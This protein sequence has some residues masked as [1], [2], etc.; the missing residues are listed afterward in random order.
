MKHDGAFHDLF[1]D[2]VHVGKWLSDELLLAF[3]G[4][5]GGP[6]KEAVQTVPYL[7]LTTHGQ[8]HY[9]GQMNETDP[10]AP[11]GRLNRSLAVEFPR[12]MCHQQIQR[13]TEHGVGYG[14]HNP[15]QRDHECANGQQSYSVPQRD[16]PVERRVGNSHHPVPASCV[17]GPQGVC[18]R[19]E[20]WEL[21]CEQQRCERPTSYI[22]RGVQRARACGPAHK[23]W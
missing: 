23:R 4:T 22:S 11:S 9:S 16:P 13:R 14:T 12:R 2:D 21:P 15:T 17:F 3:S 20:V 10:K 1:V 8:Q 19:V 7:G 6:T 18:E 5:F